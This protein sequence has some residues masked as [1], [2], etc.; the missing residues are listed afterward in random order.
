MEILLY[1]RGVAGSEKQTA[2]VSRPRP[3]GWLEVMMQ[4]GQGPCGSP[5]R[6]LRSRN[7]QTVLDLVGQARCPTAAGK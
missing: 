5:K 1:R 4:P 3:Q 6:I 7:S 2:S